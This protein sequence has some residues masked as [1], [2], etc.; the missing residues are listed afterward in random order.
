MDVEHAVAK[1]VEGIRQ[2]KR[3]LVFPPHAAWLVRLLRWLPPGLSDW[4]I[5]RKFKRLLQ[6]GKKQTV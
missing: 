1:M 4:I 5:R 2:R 3:R 6:Q